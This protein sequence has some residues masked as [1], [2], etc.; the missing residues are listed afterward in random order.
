MLRFF[1]SATGELV[2]FKPRSKG[3]AS[4]YA[5]GPT[6]YDVPHLGHART[7]ITYDVI[8]RYLRWKGLKVDL[9]VNITDVDDKIIARAKAEN[10]TESE[11]ADAYA[12]IYSEQMSRL[13]IE[14]PTRQPK[15]TEYV[16]QMLKIIS[17]LMDKNLAYVIEGAGIYFD[18]GKFSDYGKLVKRTPD[19]LRES[20]MGRV[21]ADKRKRD[22]LDFALWKA[23]KPGEPCWESEWM[24]GR[25]GWHIECVAMSLG[26]LGSGFDIHGGGTDLIFPHHE[27]EKAEAEAAGHSFARH[28]IH[29]AMVTVGGEKM[30]KS[31]GNF[32]TLEDVLSS[33]DPRALRLVMLQTHYRSDMEISSEA[34][35]AV[36]A[37]MSR[38]DGLIRRS[39]TLNL[40]PAK[41][42][43]RDILARFED[44][45][46]ND[47]A[48]PSAIGLLF[49]TASS[50]H[51]AIDKEDFK[52]AGV[53]LAA[54]L[55]LAEVLGLDLS[56]QKTEIS[57]ARA[58]EIEA[59]IDAR[60]DAR[61]AGDYGK[62]DQIR[63][64]LLEVGI[65]IEDTAQ[66]S[67]WHQ[68]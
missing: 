53:Y 9:I 61:T 14:P 38:L 40:H 18:I 37:G 20:G 64:Q 5:C 44:F 49:E 55:E 50:A 34:L 56:R 35:E 24:P 66:G 68:T 29:S 3:K 67:I 51:T 63:D 47:F 19:D 2:A 26:E 28:W 41:K 4:I 6:V 59:L 25:P 43:D 31:T 17:D 8:A 15:A 48:T 42:A 65:Q 58:Q 10:K 39:H 60:N 33:Y 32:Q 23:A 12:Q 22:S 52:K 11:I 1:D 30:A 46:D 45:M 27:N 36:Q 62:A 7:A 13:N 21:E 57:G 54:I 16:P